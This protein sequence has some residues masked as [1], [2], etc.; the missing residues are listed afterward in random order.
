MRSRQLNLWNWEPEIDG[1]SVLSWH[2]EFTT[3]LTDIFTW[4]VLKKN[5]RLQKYEDNTECV[6]QTDHITTSKYCFGLKK[7]QNHW[8]IFREGRILTYL[9]ITESVTSIP[10][11]LSPYFSTRTFD[12]NAAPVKWNLL[13]QTQAKLSCYQ[14]LRVIPSPS[15]CIKHWHF[16][17]TDTIWN[18]GYFVR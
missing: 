18:Y 7:N 3:H 12:T 5:L 16:K 9:A 10:C 8:P 2:E 6:P 15:A 1:V 13:Q 11:L 4:I 14:F 17:F